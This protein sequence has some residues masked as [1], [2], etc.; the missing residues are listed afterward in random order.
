[1]DAICTTIEIDLKETIGDAD[2]PA[3]LVPQNGVLM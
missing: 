1:L 3:P 2:V